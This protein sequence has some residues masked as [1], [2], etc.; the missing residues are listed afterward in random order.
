MF[1]LRQLRADR[2]DLLLVE[3]GGRD[4]HLCRADRHARADWL[5]PNAENRVH[6]TARAFHVPSA[7]K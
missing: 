1:E 2:H 4:Q 5:G 6:S 3:R 7:A